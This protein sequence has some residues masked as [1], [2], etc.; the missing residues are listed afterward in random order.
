M[1]LMMRRRLREV[2]PRETCDE[3][4]TRCAKVERGTGSSPVQALVCHPSRVDAEHAR[5]GQGGAIDC[6]CLTIHFAV[7]C[8]VERELTPDSLRENSNPIA[9][10]FGENCA[11]PNDGESQ[12]FAAAPNLRA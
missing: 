8:I 7:R 5:L 3:P 6:D 12:R 9:L 1:G 4:D 2:H 10:K 11:T